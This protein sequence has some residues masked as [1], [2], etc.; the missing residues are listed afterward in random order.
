MEICERVLPSD[1]L[2][3]GNSV[4]TNIERSDNCYQP[5]TE[6]FLCY[7]WRFMRDA[8][9]RT[10]CLAKKKKF[11][12]KYIIILIY[13]LFHALFRRIEF[14]NEPT[15][16]LGFVIIILLHSIVSAG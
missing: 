12:L 2:G 8:E 16:A 7:C 5:I 11:K 3:I 14:L 4:S 9:A 1:P 13:F 15:S 6:G 10:G